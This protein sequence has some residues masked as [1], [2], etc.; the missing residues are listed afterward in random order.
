MNG[1]RAMQ[2][3]KEV[4]TIRGTTGRESFGTSTEQTVRYR[5]HGGGTVPR[6]LTPALEAEAQ[7]ALHL[8]AGA[9]VTTPNQ[10]TAAGIDAN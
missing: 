8:P 10:C 2:F 9:A 4:L 3:S 6:V 1:L 5:Q 7:A